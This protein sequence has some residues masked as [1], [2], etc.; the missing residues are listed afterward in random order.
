MATAGPPCPPRSLCH[1]GL[2]RHPPLRELSPG[3]PSAWNLPVA[4]FTMASSWVQSAEPGRGQG[5]ASQLPPPR[6]S[7]QEPRP[8][9]PVSPADLPVSSAG[10]RWFPT[11]RPYL[12][13]HLQTTHRR[14]SS[15]SFVI[16][17]LQSHS[18]PPSLPYWSPSLHPIFNNH[19]LNTYYVLRQHRHSREQ[20]R[21]LLLWN[22]H[23]REGQTI[24]LQT[25]RRHFRV[26]CTLRKKNKA[27]KDV[28]PESE[29]GQRG[30]V[31][32]GQGRL[33]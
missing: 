32:G 10:P 9:Y 15:G 3:G 19:L 14:S 16:H 6:T 21:P 27:P 29:A 7:A 12:R 18:F 11:P 8:P 33:L 24:N 25:H 23:Y 4:S 2:P 28:C 30:A 22:L 1:S 26:W 5:T 17:H 20:T 31:A 13:K